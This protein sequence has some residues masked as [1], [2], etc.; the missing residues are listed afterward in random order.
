MLGF[1]K[2]I[3]PLNLAIIAL[4]MYLIRWFIIYPIISVET[5]FYFDFELQMSEFDFFL[6]VMSTIF[7]A[8]A[9]YI[10][11]DYFDLRADRINKPHRVIVGRVVKRRVAMVTHFA[12]NLIG[13][14]LGAYLAYK[15]DFWKLGIIHIFSAASLWYYSVIFKREFL[16]GNLIIA[17]MAGLVPVM[18]G[19]FEIPLLTKE[20]GQ[21]V[22]H[23]FKE[24]GVESSALDYF[25]ILYY[26][27]AGYAAFAFVATLIREI[28]KDLADIEGDRIVGCKTVPIVVGE[29]ATKGIVVALM[30]VLLAALVG[31]MYQFEDFYATLYFSIA[32]A[33]PLLISAVLTLRA[34]TRKQHLA[35]CNFVK[36]A[37]ATAVLYGLV[38]AYTL[39]LQIT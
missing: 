31:V 22:F 29:K 28:Q 27:I 5:V 26:W 39:Q 1:F 35:A 38:F 24:Y 13:I 18:V 19:V 20:Y 10:I 9:G 12:F 17:L 6:L 37:M 33:V 16:I 32:V 11:N 25:K 23:A 15:V 8:A 21:T 36:I 30:V 14:G 4:T 34:Q 3:R 7:I 2:L